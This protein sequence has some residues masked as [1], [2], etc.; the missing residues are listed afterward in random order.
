MGSCADKSHEFSTFTHSKSIKK[1]ININSKD[2]LNNR[3]NLFT[4]ISN[5]YVL[6]LGLAIFSFIDDT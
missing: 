4:F 3:R 1:S 2:R 6:G 5:F